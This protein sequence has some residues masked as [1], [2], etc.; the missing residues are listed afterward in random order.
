MRGEAE[1]GLRQTRYEAA[2]VPLAVEVVSPDS[3]DRDRDTKPRKYAAAGIPHFWLVGMAGERDH[4]AVHTYEPDPVTKGLRAHR[5]SPRTAEADR[6]LHHRHRSR[7]NRSYVA[8]PV[9]T[10]VQPEPSPVALFV[11]GFVPRRTLPHHEGEAGPK[12]GRGDTGVK[13]PARFATSVPCM[14]H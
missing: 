14:A 4:P 6:P 9:A 12:V 1:R 2:D 10:A 5:D 7:G 11:L 8:Q 3:E 13:S